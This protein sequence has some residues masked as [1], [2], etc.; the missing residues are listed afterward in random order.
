M[1]NE[2]TRI[3]ESS[4]N[5]FADLGLPNADEHMLKAQIVVQLRR[6]IEERML[7]QTKAATLIGMAQPDLSNVLRGRFKGYSVERL[8]RLLT[9]LDQDIEIRVQPKANETQPARISVTSVRR[10][11]AS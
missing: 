8:M 4:G 2:D 5:V 10:M 3:V 1:N 11:P 6:L 7:T 9:A